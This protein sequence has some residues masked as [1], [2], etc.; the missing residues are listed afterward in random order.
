ME[1]GNTCYPTWRSVNLP[2]SEG[3]NVVKQM[4]PNVC[5]V[6]GQGEIRRP[7]IKEVT[8]CTFRRKQL[9]VHKLFV[10]GGGT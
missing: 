2:P 9:K 10:G 1:I 5:T 8:T 4:R 6:G 7:G 3:V